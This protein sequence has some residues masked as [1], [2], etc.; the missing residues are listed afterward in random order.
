MA[1]APAALLFQESECIFV[2]MRDTEEE[3]VSIGNKE[4][5]EDRGLMDIFSRCLSSMARDSIIQE[6]EEV[7]IDYSA[8]AW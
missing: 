3:N 5:E 8:F 7:K 2:L 6:R 4:A 1:A